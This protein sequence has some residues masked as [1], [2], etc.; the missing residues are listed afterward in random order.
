MLNQRITESPGYGGDVLQF[1]ETADSVYAIHRVFL[2]NQKEKRA[3]R[4][5]SAKVADRNITK[6]CINVSPEVYSRLVD[7]CSRNQALL[8]R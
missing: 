5:K 3:E 6:G 8:I 2:L 4:L 7:C 1:K